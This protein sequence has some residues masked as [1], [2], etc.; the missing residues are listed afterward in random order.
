MRQWPGSV[1]DLD[2]CPIVGDARAFLL[3][4]KHLDDVAQM[5]ATDVFARKVPRAAL[6]GCAFFRIWCAHALAST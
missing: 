2:F 4:A 5:D 1:A 3:V 6:L